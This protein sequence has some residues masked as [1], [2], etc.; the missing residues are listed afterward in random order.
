MRI[1]QPVT[2]H[3]GDSG[4]LVYMDTGHVL[5]LVQRQQGASVALRLII[6]PHV[7]LG[8]DLC[9]TARQ[10][11]QLVKGAPGVEGLSDADR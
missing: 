9:L 2:T 5:C 3:A 10:W 6:G 11:T 7:L 4:H 8:A 1:A